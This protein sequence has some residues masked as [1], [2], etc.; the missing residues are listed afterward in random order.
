MTVLNAGI[1]LLQYAGYNPLGLFPEGTGYHDAFILYNGQFMGT[2]GNVDTLSA[3]LCLMVPLFY[4]TYLLS[5]RRLALIPMGQA[6]L[7]WA[8]PG[9]PRDL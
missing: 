1:G 3:F 6:C 2:L 9:Y 4:G 5:G 8:W 7:R